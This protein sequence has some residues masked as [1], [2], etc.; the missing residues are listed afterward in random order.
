MTAARS[1]P[2]TGA[3]SG[4]DAADE[5]AAVA[6]EVTGAPPE[7]TGSPS[8]CSTHAP[9]RIVHPHRLTTVVLATFDRISTS[10]KLESWRSAARTLP[11]CRMRDARAEGATWWGKPPTPARSRDAPERRS[12]P[13]PRANELGTQ[14]SPARASEVEARW[15]ELTRVVPALWLAVVPAPVLGKRWS[16]VERRWHEV[17]AAFP[18][19][20]DR[21][22]GTLCGRR[23]EGPHGIRT[24]P[25]A[26]GG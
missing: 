25:R 10:A 18:A 9:S 26:G 7:A 24:H 16:E 5:V 22:G 2:W 23:F 12:G 15:P 21:A 11:T 8:G 13:S 1:R 14:T 19:E 17:V 20:F 6:V 4:S 3:S